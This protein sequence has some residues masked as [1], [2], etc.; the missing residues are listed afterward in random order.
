MIN[1]IKKYKKLPIHIVE[2]HN[3][4]LPFIY[5]SIG[6]KHF[7]LEN[8]TL[9]H[10]DSHPDMLIPKGMDAETVWEKDDLFLQL[11]IENWILP[12]VYAG[13]F[14][15][16]IWIKP[17]WANQIKDGI[18]KFFIGKCKKTEQIRLTSTHSY[19]VSEGLY[20]VKEDL[21]NIKEITLQVVTM[22]SNSQFEW[23]SLLNNDTYYVLDIDLDFFSTKNPFLTIYEKAEAYTIL[24]QLYQF[25][26][27]I[28]IT[29]TQYLQQVVKSRVDQ[30]SKL[31]LIFNYLDECNGKLKDL[32]LEGADAILDT[33]SQL[34]SRLAEAYPGE[35][36]DWSM[37]HEAGCTCD[38]SDLPHHVSSREN[39]LKMIEGPFQRFL[40]DLPTLPTLITISRSSEDDYCPPADV[41]F[42]QENVIKKISQII[43]S[44]EMKYD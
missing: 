37:L 19:F 15:T 22:D 11:S 25:N 18:S 44:I 39:I 41:D 31:E 1:M 43:P 5:R 32:K 12:A 40:R 9:I 36:I 42:I 34:V 28:N 10:F 29:D 33:I 8:N 26:Y 23:K 6:S 17:F 2:N 20:V 14:T 7:P 13:H 3:E 16:I 21:L 4:V 38:D 24:K 27:D 30:L 35:T